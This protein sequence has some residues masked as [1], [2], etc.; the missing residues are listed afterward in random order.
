M[1][2]KRWYCVVVYDDYGNIIDRANFRTLWEAKAFVKRERLSHY[3]IERIRGTEYGDIIASETVEYVNRGGMDEKM[4]RIVVELY[5]P[6]TGKVV[7]RKYFRFSR[8]FDKFLREYK[9]G[10]YPNLRWRIAE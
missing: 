4:K 5:E 10:R 9:E 3:E 8:E 7:L 1:A 6:D 2:L